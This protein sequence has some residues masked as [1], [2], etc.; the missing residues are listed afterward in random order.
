M[1]DICSVFFLFFSPMAF[2]RRVIKRL[3]YLLSGSSK[4]AQKESSIDWTIDDFSW[5]LQLDETVLKFLVRVESGSFVYRLHIDDFYRASACLCMHSMSMHAERDTVLPI[6]SVRLSVSLCPFVCLSNANTVWKR[7]D[8]SSHFLDA[9]I[10]H[11]S[12]FSA[13][14]RCNKI[15]RRTPSAGAFYTRG[16]NSCAEYRHLSR[17]RYEIRL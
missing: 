15:P 17:N 5:K 8:V 2:V 14:P 1:C 6:L 3:T 7:M 16:E 12:T 4:T 11:Y 13:P 10:G 9:L